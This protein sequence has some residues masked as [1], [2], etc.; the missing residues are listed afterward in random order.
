MLKA[1]NCLQGERYIRIAEG[2]AASEDFVF[3]WLANRIAL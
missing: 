3:G 1:L 2:R